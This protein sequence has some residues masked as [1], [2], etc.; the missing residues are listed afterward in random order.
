MGFADSENVDSC[1]HTCLSTEN[2][3][4]TNRGDKGVILQYVLGVGCAIATPGIFLYK[5]SRH[6]AMMH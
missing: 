2:I 4:H 3:T 1:L 6:A 5:H